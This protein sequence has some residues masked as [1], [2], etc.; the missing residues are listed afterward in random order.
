MSKVEYPEGA[1]RLKIAVA[2][3][4]VIGLSCAFEL[5]RRGHLV[6]CFDGGDLRRSTSWA[7]AGMIAPAYEMYLHG[8]E[9]GGAFSE[10]AFESARLWERFAPS[11]R[12]AAGMP[13]GYSNAPTLAVAL[14]SEARSAL[15]ALE[16]E[17]NGRGHTAYWM[18][19]DAAMERYGLSGRVQAVLQLTS[20]HQIDNRKLLIAL[21]RA[22]IKLGGRFV[23]QHVE[24]LAE[25]REQAEG[26]G[27]DIIVWARGSHETGVTRDVKGQALSLYPVETMP[28]EVIRY[29][30]GY[31]VPKPDRIV[32][33]ATSEATYAHAGVDAATIETLYQSACDVL[34]SLRQAI[35]QES[36]SGVRPGSVDA[37]P[38][39]GALDEGEFIASGHFR[40]GVLL[41]PATAHRIADMIEGKP[42]AANAGCFSPTR[43]EL[44]TV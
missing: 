14:D 13:V 37:L 29:G 22:L 34:P 9:S 1:S 5:L 12:Q 8:G 6:T 27:F 21:R 43:A 15:R 23:A 26:N 44:E 19:R 35:R 40:N 38:I 24:T 16:A 3:A 42:A 33:G 11:I 4:G 20:D 2:G 7:A 10:L 31:I 28:A 18:G 36:W 17:L 30:G 32:I 25:A 39:I 41:A